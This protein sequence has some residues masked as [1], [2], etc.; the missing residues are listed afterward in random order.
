MKIWNEQV[1]AAEGVWRRANVDSMTRFIV[2]LL[3]LMSA[4]VFAAT[5]AAQT[6]KHFNR[7]DLSAA[8]AL[9]DRAMRDSTAWQ[10][11]ESL[12]TEVGPRFSGTP[13]DR[14]AV[15]WALDKMRSLG[16][17][18]VRTQEVDVPQWVRGEAEFAVIEPWP[19]PMPALAL[20]GT[21]GTPDAGIE[22]EAVMVKDLAAL[23]ALPAG[24]VKDRIVF[25]NN[26]IERRRDWSEYSRAVS[27]RGGGPAAAS[28]LGAVGVVIR[29]LSTGTHRIPHTGGS[30]QPQDVPRIPAMSLSNPDADALARQFASGRTVRLRMKSTARDLPRQKSANVIGEI[31][32]TG[33]AHE[34][35]ILGAHLD[36]WDV[37][38]GAI[39]NA[40]GVGLVL[41]AAHLIRAQGLKPRR[42]LRVVLFANEENGSAGSRTYAASQEQDLENHV[43][44]IESDYGAGP[45]WQFS[46]RVHPGD[47]AVIDEMYRVLEPLEMGRGTNEA[48]GNADLSPLAARGMPI[49]GPELDGTY[50]LDAHHSANDTL[51]QIDPAAIRQSAAT[52][53]VG[54][55]LGAQYTGKWQ[56]VAPRPRR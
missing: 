35:I 47:V 11:A 29:S 43:L 1:P 45:V 21:I 13:G 51:A 25:F 36:S 48:P 3:G 28:A 49:L 33:L 15:A 41:T 31:P 34:I 17:E 2:T 46:T 12:T 7:T 16:F 56:R 5:A 22:A 53:A 55:W 27:V 26:P 18:N 10:L 44:G 24:A 14:A 8:H 52:F 30:R 42:T 9:R 32:G 38:V 40:A 19:Q 39:D 37:G 6:T 50:Y 23:A 4:L 20:G 54:V